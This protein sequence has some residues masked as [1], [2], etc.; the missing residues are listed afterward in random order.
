MNK[1]HP[2]AAMAVMIPVIR[3]ASAHM[4]LPQMSV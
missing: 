1:K 3:L 4:V 2:V